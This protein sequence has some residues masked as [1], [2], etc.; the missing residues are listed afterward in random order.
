[1]NY[2]DGLNMARRAGWNGS[3]V[4][5]DDAHRL[6][7]LAAGG[8]V[9]RLRLRVGASLDDVLRVADAVYVMV[10]EALTHARR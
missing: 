6:A 4:S 3:H 10:W 2:T 9:E 8:A 1:M 7:W 5:P